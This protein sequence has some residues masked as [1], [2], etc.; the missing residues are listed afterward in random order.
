MGMGASRSPTLGAG[1]I[2][3]LFGPAYK[4]TQFWV[5]E[6]EAVLS[7]VL[8]YCR[9]IEVQVCFLGLSRGL[10]K[11]WDVLEA[12]PGAAALGC[13]GAAWWHCPCPLFQT[14]MVGL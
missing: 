14:C 10:A 1:L 7:Y 13:L 3:H 4:D 12:S 9:K 8:I 2:L 11:P 5:A 6:F